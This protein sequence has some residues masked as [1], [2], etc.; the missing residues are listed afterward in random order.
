M[1]LSIILQLSM[2]KH[3]KMLSHNY[4]YLIIN[5]YQYRKQVII[6]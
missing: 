2:Q 1:Q 3:F 6:I 4:Q 5:N